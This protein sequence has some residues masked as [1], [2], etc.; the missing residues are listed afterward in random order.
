MQKPK[1]PSR[2]KRFE[3][4]R[5]ARIDT[6]PRLPPEHHTNFLRRRIGIAATAL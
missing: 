2:K 4:M 6:W 5:L 3:H 1:P